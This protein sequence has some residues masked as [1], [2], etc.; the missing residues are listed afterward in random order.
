MTNLPT[1]DELDDF[2]RLAEHAAHGGLL[3]SAETQLFSTALP[4]VMAAARSAVVPPATTV[5]F[6]AIGSFCWGLGDTPEEA[7]TNW[8]NNSGQPK[9][10]PYVKL[11]VS[12]LSRR[13]QAE[14]P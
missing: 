9:R 8:K 3:T 11:R 12:D 1:P 13:H 5:V 7:L 4:G 2:G 14:R 10:A 6:L